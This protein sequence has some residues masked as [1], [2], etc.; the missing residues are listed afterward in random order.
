MKKFLLF[1]LNFIFILNAC[2]CTRTDSRQVVNKDIIAVSIVPEAT[3]AEKA[4]GGDFEIVT[5]IPAG[6]SPE[7][8]EPTPVIM[9]RLSKAK[10]YF[11]IGVQSEIS[12]LPSIKSE[13]QIIRLEKKVSEVYSD[14][15]I[16]GGR[17]PHIWLSVKRA[18][19]MVAEIADVLGRIKPE[20]REKYTANANN[21]IAE[22]DKLDSDIKA[23]FNNTEENKFI[24]FHP[25]F[26][27]FADEYSIK[28]Y[29]LEEGGKEATPKRLAEMVDFA[30]KE[31]IKVIFYQSQS[32]L[33][34]AEAFAEGIGGEAAMLNPLASD[35]INNLYAM[36]KAIKKAAG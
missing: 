11:S 32:Q 6:A 20:S 34:S 18:K 8:Y 28:M 10:A 35:Y 1:L 30:K 16:D 17:D 21:Y 27:Y 23:L 15:S 3:F 36:A 9:R 4:C 25:A 7:T 33:K 5:A 14:L 29:S 2:A 26:G 13:T 12:I 24:A 19:V 22:L 31:N